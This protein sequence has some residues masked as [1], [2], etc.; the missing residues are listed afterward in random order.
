MKEPKKQREPKSKTLCRR[1][2]MDE[3]MIGRIINGRRYLG[4][5][6]WEHVDHELSRTNERRD[7]TEYR[8]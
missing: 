5:N 7:A 8:G 3:M 2:C 1:E 6:C 4:N